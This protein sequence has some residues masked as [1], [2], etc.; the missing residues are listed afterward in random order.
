[1]YYKWQASTL[2]LSVR[3]FRNEHPTLSSYEIRV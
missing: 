1:M 2:G 3:A